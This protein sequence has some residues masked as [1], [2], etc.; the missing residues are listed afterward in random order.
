MKL[1]RKQIKQII[2][3]SILVED[4]NP[5]LRGLD[6][7]GV[8]GTSEPAKPYPDPNFLYDPD[9]E[10]QQPATIED[11][12]FEIRKVANYFNDVVIPWLKDLDDMSDLVVDDDYATIV[13]KNPD[14]LDWV[15]IVRSVC[16]LE[17]GDR[18]KKEKYPIKSM[19]HRHHTQ[20]P[21]I[22]R[23]AVHGRWG[24]WPTE[25]LMAEIEASADDLGVSLPF[26]SEV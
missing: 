18:I 12:K 6:D 14:D 11:G 4:E 8:E 10:S 20:V 7:F 16:P 24:V 2:L 13:R 19:P 21:Y 17:K 9:Y 26:E 23:G 22:Y 25:R 1:T 15:A 3:E 5:V